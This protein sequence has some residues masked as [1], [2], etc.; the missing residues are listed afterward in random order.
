[1][2][3]LL[4]FSATVDQSSD[5]VACHYA[6]YTG[7]SDAN[8]SPFVNTSPNLRWE[9]ICLEIATNACVAALPTTI[10]GKRNLHSVDLQN[11]DDS[12]LVKFLRVLVSRLDCRSTTCQLPS[13][14]ALLFASQLLY[15][16]SSFPFDSSLRIATYLS[17]RDPDCKEVPYEMHSQLRYAKESNRCHDLVTCLQ[18]LVPCP[19]PCARTSTSKLSAL[20]FVVFIL[21][22]P[23]VPN[24]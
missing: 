9:L 17:Q 21:Y 1:M 2:E 11:S 3:P 8:D 4:V 23:L 13:T 15:P 18:R 5:D 14:L 20:T 6:L 22:C 12:H 7:S 10:T 19:V 16:P 24:V